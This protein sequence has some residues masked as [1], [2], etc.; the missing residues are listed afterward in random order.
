MFADDLILIAKTVEELQRK[1]NTLS[2]FCKEKKLEINEKNP[3]VWCL[4]AVTNYVKPL[5]INNTNIENVKSYKYLGFT[6]GAK[7]CSLI[8]TMADLSIKAKRAIF[9]LNNKIKISFLPP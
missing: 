9:T 8:N 3:N 1:I 5:F 4:I 2:D 6:I 7:N